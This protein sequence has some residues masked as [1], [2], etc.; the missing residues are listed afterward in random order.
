MCGIAEKK[1]R[2]RMP[3]DCCQLKYHIRFA[4]TVMMG[5]NEEPENGQFSKEKFHGTKTFVAAFIFFF[6]QVPISGRWLLLFCRFIKA[7]TFLHIK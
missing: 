1:V 6:S 4:L 5:A 2:A 7:M 3:A